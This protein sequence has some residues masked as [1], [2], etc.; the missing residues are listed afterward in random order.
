VTAS[1]GDTCGGTHRG[2]DRDR[3]HLPPTSWRREPPPRRR[4]GIPAADALPPPSSALHR[5]TFVLDGE[6]ETTVELQTHRGASDLAD[7]DLRSARGVQTPRERCPFWCGQGPSTLDA[8]AFFFRTGRP[9]DGSD[10]LLLQHVASGGCPSLGDI[11]DELRL[12]RCQVRDPVDVAGAWTALG[13]ARDRL[14]RLLIARQRGLAGLLARFDNPLVQLPQTR[15]GRLETSLRACR[16]SRRRRSC[17]AGRSRAPSLPGART[18]GPGC[19]RRRA[20]GRALGSSTS[21]RRLC[22]R[23]RL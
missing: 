21:R 23:L 4:V 8:S 17:A 2:V 13:R 14:Q 22:T 5:V 9:G 10:G 19:S 1:G 6:Q 7:L 15:R 16:C 20:D 12:S 3:R 18:C 11:A